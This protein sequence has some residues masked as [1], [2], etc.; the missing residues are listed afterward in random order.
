[1]SAQVYTPKDI[2][3]YL[4][5]FG[6]FYFVFIFVPSR[7]AEALTAWSASSLLNLLGFTSLYGLDTEGVYLTLE[8]GARSVLVYII[9]ECTAIHVLGV[10][11]GLV[12]PLKGVETSRKLFGSI[13]GVFSIYVMNI[14][15][16]TLTLFLSAYEVPPVSWFI[17]EPTVETFHYPISFI[18]GVVGI[19]I[20]ILII[21]RYSVPEL[22]DFLASLPDTIKGFFK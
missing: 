7:W 1:M 4:T 22:G 2:V 12:I 9:R 11:L 8:G 20:T 16:I 19:I 21:D 5:I 13:I 18:F 10:I 14:I 15:R 17:S 3:R 6:I